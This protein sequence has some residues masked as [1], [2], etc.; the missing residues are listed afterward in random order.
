MSP[1]VQLFS[2]PRCKGGD[3]RSLPG[4]DGSAFCPWCGNSVAAGAAPPPPP[5]SPQVAP[6]PEPAVGSGAQDA[7]EA[8]VRA[9]RDRIAELDRKCGRAESDLRQELDKKQEI[10]KAVLAELGRLE[11]QLSE[12]KA[13]LQRKEEE[14]K[15]ALAET[16]R[17]QE[18]LGKERKKA[19]EQDGTRKSSEEKA[20]RA[21]ESELEQSRKAAREMQDARDTARR[22]AEAIRSDLAKKMETSK[23]EIA[24]LR[25]RIVAG[26]ARFRSVKDSG[27]EL[28]ALKARH[29]D[30][31]RRAEKERAELQEKAS[32]LQSDVE[33]KEQR[34]R[35][36]QLL[37]KTL[38]ERLND[39]TSRRF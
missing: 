21:L 14:H 39:L 19:D 24:E 11:S 12:M 37:V 15:S 28:T 27:D 33:K 31:R 34:V 16:S 9:L 1:S 23:T 2:C 5:S 38:G 8:V 36:L 22:E 32:T 30:L 25:A 26:D 18:D 20:A 10:K 35:D 3:F 7:S 13:L 6:V 4:P 17:L 29:E